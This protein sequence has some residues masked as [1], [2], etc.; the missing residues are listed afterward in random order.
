MAHPLVGQRVTRLF[1]APT[2]IPG[3]GDG[4]APMFYEGCITSV[5]EASRD[6]VI[7]FDDGDRLRVP[8][9]ACT[10][11]QRARMRHV[12]AAEADAIE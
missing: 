3:R 9:R 4:D 1:W 11:Q 6:A 5:D 7:N 10:L 2:P 8:V 12:E